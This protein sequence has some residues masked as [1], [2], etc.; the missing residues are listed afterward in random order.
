MS[1]PDSKTD[2]PIGFPLPDWQPRPWPPLTSMSGR[3]CQLEPLQAGNKERHAQALFDAF[4]HDRDHRNWTYLPYGPF[5]SYEA[6]FHWLSSECCGKDPQFHVILD[7]KSGKAVGM[8]SYLRITPAVGVIE[9]G[10]IHFSPLLQRTALATETMFLMMQRVF[11]ELGYRRYEWKCDSLNAPSMRA[12]KRLGFSYEGIFRQATI[13]K[14]RNRDT[15][16]LAI[17]DQDWQTLKPAYQAWLAPGNF[18]TNGNQ[19][20]SLGDFRQND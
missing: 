18:D 2:L 1:Q 15:A 5:D 17:T 19:K 13:Y 7:N 9:V 11:D 4:S 20:R 14:N 3:F 8:A 10:H 16:W 12:A 6:F